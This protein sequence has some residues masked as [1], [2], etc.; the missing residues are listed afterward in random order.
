MEEP[1][2]KD[3]LFAE[4]FIQKI[5]AGEKGAFSLEEE[6]LRKALQIALAQLSKGLEDKG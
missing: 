5:L 4:H 1:S 3:L 6:D 2:R